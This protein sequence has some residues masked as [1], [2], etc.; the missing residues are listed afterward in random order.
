MPLYST[1]ENRRTS[2]PMSLWENWRANIAET[3]ASAEFS[4]LKPLTTEP[5]LLC[6]AAQLF[7]AALT[8]VY[9]IA[10]PAEECAAKFV[11][12]AIALASHSPM[13]KDETTH[14]L[15]NRV[16]LLG[17]REFH[18]LYT[19]LLPDPM[20]RMAYQLVVEFKQIQDS[21]Q[22]NLKQGTSDEEHMGTTVASI[23]AS[24]KH[25]I[26]T[27]PQGHSLNPSVDDLHEKKRHLRAQLCI[28]QDLYTCDHAHNAVY[29]QTV[30][31]VRAIEAHTA[32]VQETLEVLERRYHAVCAELQTAKTRLVHWKDTLKHEVENQ[33]ARATQKSAHQMQVWTS[34]TEFM[35]VLAQ[36][37]AAHPLPKQS[38]N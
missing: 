31:Q 38:T 2:H 20:G 34:A 27:M 3:I 1:L 32:D 30:E 37:P 36:C 19:P 33:A 13:G 15:L 8:C 24:M 23:I 29:T 26:A 5:A 16:Y 6:S 4:T 9:S 25:V 17:V 11:R 14:T 10:P 18:R 35:R 21:E 7:A 22:S 12:G 28:Q